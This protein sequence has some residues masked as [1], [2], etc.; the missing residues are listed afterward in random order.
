MNNDIFLIGAQTGNQRKIKSV[1]SV[2]SSWAF[3]KATWH[4][5]CRSSPSPNRFSMEIHGKHRQNT[6]AKWPSCTWCVSLR[7]ALLF[8]FDEATLRNQHLHQ[9]KSWFS[10][11]AGSRNS[12]QSIGKFIRMKIS[13]APSFRAGDENWSFQFN[14]NQ[15]TKQMNINAPTGKQQILIWE[16][17]GLSCETSNWLCSGQ[18]TA[19]LNGEMCGRF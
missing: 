19:Q 18:V 14:S 12:S 4:Q 17:S 9:P 6:L 13:S 10:P 5:L 11:F 7:P 2:S 16:A 8:H 15:S 3:G 1:F